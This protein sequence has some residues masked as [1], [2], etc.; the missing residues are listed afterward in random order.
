MKYQMKENMCAN[1][2]NMLL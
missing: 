1:G 2:L